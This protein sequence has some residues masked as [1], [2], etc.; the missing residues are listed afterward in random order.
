MYVIFG[1]YGNPTVALMQWAH[2]EKL[3]DVYVVSVDTGWAAESWLARCEAGYALARRYGFQVQVLRPKAQM[4]DLVKDRGSFPSIKFQWC[5]GFLKGLP[6]LDWLDGEQDIDGVA[7]ILTGKRKIVSRTPHLLEEFIEESEHY[8][9]RRV[10]NPLINKG[11][12]SFKALIERSGLSLLA[13]RSLECDPCIH[14]QAADFQRLASAD[15]KKTRAVEVLVDKTMFERPIDE[16]VRQYKGQ[17]CATVMGKH[18]QFSMGCG[19]EFA[20]GA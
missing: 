20:C 19:D 18:G 16:M 11:D 3:A 13:H 6:L 10:W 8:G 15:C 2:E 12:D 17:A 9:H 5:P 14:A 7:T 1:N 4:A